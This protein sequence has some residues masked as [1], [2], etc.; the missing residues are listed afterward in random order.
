M[1]R[2]SAGRHCTALWPQI[3][4]AAVHGSRGC[5]AVDYGKARSVMGRSLHRR[6]RD[7][8]RS[9]R[10]GVRGKPE[11]DGVHLHDAGNAGGAKQN[12]RTSYHDQLLRAGTGHKGVG[13][14][15]KLDKLQASLASWRGKKHGKKRDLLSLIGLLSHACK[16]IRPGRSFLRRLIDLSMTVRVLSRPIRLNASARS[17][18]E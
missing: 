9:R 7:N 16:A 14:V 8:G 4:P 17:D 10:T 5:L 3:S 12:G 13:V 1:E 6:F 11:R 2:G 18:I 15:D